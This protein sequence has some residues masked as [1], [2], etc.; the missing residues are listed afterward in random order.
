FCSTYGTPEFDEYGAE[1]GKEAK[2]WKVYVEE[3]DKWDTELV[4]GWN[5]FLIESSNRLRVDPVDSS[6]ETLL[7]ISRTLLAISN[8]T[9]APDLDNP[10]TANL[11]TTFKPSYSAVLVNALWY[12]SLSLSVATSFMA[13]LAKDWCHSFMT[14]RT[15]HP[16]AQARRRQQKWNMIE[17]WKM[18][19][20]IRMLPSLIH[21]SLY[22]WETNIGVAIPVIGITGLAVVFYIWS[23]LTAIWVHDFPYTTVVSKI[24]RSGPLIAVLRWALQWTM[25]PLIC[26]FYA[27]INRCYTNDWIPSLDAPLGYL[28]RIAPQWRQK[29]Q[30]FVGL[31]TSCRMQK[32][33][34][35]Q[36][37]LTS[38]A[39]SW[40]IEYCEVP[41][42]VETAL[43]AIAGASVRL[44]HEPLEKCKAS[45]QISRRLVSGHLYKGTESDSENATISR[46]VRA[47]SFLGSKAQ[48]DKL[49]PTDTGELEVM[50]WDLQFK[51]E[52][53]V[54]ELITEGHFEPNNRNL[55]ALRIGGIAASLSLRA[56]DNN[57]DGRAVPEFK[58]ILG[59]L[60]RHAQHEKSEKKRLHRA[61]CLSL[62]NAAIL[63]SACSARDNAS[64]D[65]V[66]VCLQIL[67]DDNYLFHLDLH[68]AVPLIVCSLL[69]HRIS[70]SERM[71]KKA[72]SIYFHPFFRVLIDQQSSNKRCLAQF[73]WSGVS[74]ILSNPTDYGIDTNGLHQY[75]GIL[76]RATSAVF[77]I[78]EELSGTQRSIMGGSSSRSSRVLA[79]IQAM[80]QIYAISQTETPRKE[81]YIFTAKSI[82]CI[83][84]ESVDR[85]SWEFLSHLKF[86]RPS[87]KFH[88]SLH[89]RGI[90]PILKQHLEDDS[91]SNRFIAAS[92]IWLLCTIYLNPP[93]TTTPKSEDEP[94]TETLLEL[95]KLCAPVEIQNAQGVEQFQVNI[96]QR[97]EQLCENARWIEEHN[98]RYV[99]RVLECVLQSRGCAPGDP[100]WSRID[101]VLEGV[102]EH[103]RS[104]GSFTSLPKRQ[105]S[106]KNGPLTNGKITSSPEHRSISMGEG[107]KESGDAD[108]EVVYM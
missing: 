41:R 17:H 20:L 37:I 16:C 40:L 86:P 108:E 100:R 98:I 89:D 57:Q 49:L 45:L 99:Y 88:Q 73:V 68:L 47:L 104:L 13:M 43:Q 62:V 93:I 7:I 81:E 11:T 56:L 55:K 46:Y 90:I 95:L 6:T 107:E 33:N 54:A 51:N 8:N 105:P 72:R 97:I 87:A 3:T 26:R 63:L 23:S 32:E 52:N 82:L 50:V 25:L 66:D 34:P 38:S 5:K 80:R 85:C 78:W 101:Q 67:Q 9:R 74:V 15:G 61:A 10:L 65:L 94:S 96:G 27:F 102:P 1:L 42:S 30:S 79:R 59:L 71:D 60:Q 39:L 4:D 22:V 58:Q 69:Q 28:I 2:V 19:R 24:L 83:K 35:E 36:D 21:L 70:N 44:P 75:Q 14:G 29:V 64:A 84:S 31:D 53:T 12:L 103:L 77:C 92:Q 48:H 18:R 91:P 76:E 106:S